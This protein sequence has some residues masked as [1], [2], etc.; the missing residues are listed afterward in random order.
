MNIM[1]EVKEKLKS[2]FQR[3]GLTAKSLAETGDL[4]LLLD[5]RP[6]DLAKI[7]LQSASR[8]LHEQIVMLQDQTER[9]MIEFVDMSINGFLNDLTLVINSYS[10]MFFGKYAPA[11]NE[12]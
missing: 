2:D 3:P 5:E 4:L 6:S 9:D 7:L 1:D 10:G 8:R 11:D 12:M